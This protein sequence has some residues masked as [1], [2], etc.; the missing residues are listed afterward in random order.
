LAKTIFGLSN[1]WPK[2]FF[3]EAI[4]SILVLVH[5]SLSPF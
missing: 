1:F 2:L 4:L 3:D 5:S